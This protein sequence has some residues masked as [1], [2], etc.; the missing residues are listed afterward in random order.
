MALKVAVGQVPSSQNE[1]SA[2]FEDPIWA[3]VYASYCFDTGESPNLERAR[4]FRDTILQQNPDNRQDRLT[5]R[6]LRLGPAA[7]SCLALQMKGRGYTKVDI[8]D[9]Q[10]G[11]HA[12]LSVRGLLRAFPKLRW[13]GLAGNLITS[14]GIQELAEEL[15]TNSTLEGL[16]LGGAEGGTGGPGRRPNVIESAGV[17]SVLQALQRNASSALTSLNLSHVS[18]SAEAGRH[19]AE[20]LEHDRMLQNLDLSS[21]PLSSEGVCAVLPQ[22]SRLRMLD[23]ADTGCRGELIQ[24]RLCGML[25]KSDR[26]VHISLARNTLEARPVRRIARALAGCDSLCS[27]N[28][29]GTTMDTEGVTA[30]ADAML[31]APVQSLTELDLS[32]N[33]LSQPEAAT[34]LAH[35]VAK[36]VLQ[37]L[38]LNRNALGD[39][40]IRELAEA[41]DPQVCPGTGLQ[42]L[43]LSGCR[44][45]AAGVGHLLSCLATNE[46]LM[47]LRLSDNYLDAGLDMSQIEQLT[48]LQELHLSGNRLS[49]ST[50]QRAAQACARNRQRARDEEPHTLRAEVH[51]LLFQEDKLGSARHRVAEDNEEITSRHNAAEHAVKE[52][53]QL[54]SREAE[55]QRHLQRQIQIEESE[56]AASKAELV[57]RN[58]DLE[59]KARSYEAMQQ[60]YRRKLQEKENELLELQVQSEQ[61]DNLLERRKVQHPKEV[62]DINARIKNATAEAEQLHQAARAMKEQ[63]K[64]LKEKSLIDFNP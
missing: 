32:S 43:E 6:C 16:V 7:L 28:L 25:E 22:C 11:D 5:L 41:L 61:V 48:H 23:I 55:V 54:R 35:T 53:H 3:E 8:S 14:D 56:L 50:I 57:T 1:L 27:L 64:A 13:L 46:T 45:G 37:V 63:F 20:F 59:Q 19:L 2:V 52:L 44:I 26:L 10:L 51:R 12:V 39:A 9:N 62:E 49:H 60:E 36:S 17:F 47:V 33:Q 58:N 34:A 18:L 30:L 42:I 21:N 29:E 38:R 24:T 31:A 15:E 40:G 4:R